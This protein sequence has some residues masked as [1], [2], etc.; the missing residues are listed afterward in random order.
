MTEVR[1]FI[2]LYLYYIVLAVSTPIGPFPIHLS[3]TPENPARLKFNVLLP[4]N[5]TIQVRLSLRLIPATTVLE[6][7]SDSNVNGPSALPL[8]KKKIVRNAESEEA[9][10]V[11]DEEE[12]L[13][14]TTIEPVSKVTKNDSEFD[15]VLPTTTP[16]P[17]SS[18]SEFKT[19]LSTTTTTIPNVEEESK[20]EN[21]H[22]VTME[23]AIE[24]F[25]KHLIKKEVEIAGLIESN[26]PFFR[27][28]KLEFGDNIEIAVRC[29]YNANYKQ[30]SLKITCEEYKD[31][32]SVR[33]YSNGELA[34]LEPQVSSDIEYVDMGKIKQTLSMNISKK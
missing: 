8:M 21:I 11:A 30:K 22:I 1:Y 19:E 27:H 24:L 13:E 17:T 20:L 25:R 31:F 32:Q 33:Y 15:S 6:N 23:E 12:V 7:N 9:V 34:Q 10:A 26:Q 4:T 2:F 18:N 5:E 14:K 28:F 16:I 3:T 29:T